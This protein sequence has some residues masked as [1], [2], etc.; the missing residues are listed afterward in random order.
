V[1]TLQ[2]LVTGPFG[3]GKTQFISTISDIPMV[4]TERKMTWPLQGS[5]KDHTTVAMDYG[6]V[7]IDQTTIHLRGTPGQERFDFMLSILSRE[8]DGQLFL[9]DSTSPTEYD[10]ARHL[11]TLL[12]Q[13]DAPPTLVVANK[14]DLPGAASLADI[15]KSL[16]IPSD[17]PLSACNS[18][19]KKSVR[20][21]LVQL[22]SLIQD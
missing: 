13:E 1:R 8:V 12:S 10:S 7:Q 14:Q 15:R 9:L 18:T 4:T 16:A 20:P 11:L 2:I 19:D 17:I 22:V 5:T 21:I 3:V 6:R